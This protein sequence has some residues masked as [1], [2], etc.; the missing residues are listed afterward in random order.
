MK[1]KNKPAEPFV[2]VSVRHWV[3]VDIDG[4]IAIPVSE[5]RRRMNQEQERAEES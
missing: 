4:V 1:D 3:G 5:F 2:Y